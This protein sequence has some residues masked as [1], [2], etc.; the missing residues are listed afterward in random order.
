MFTKIKK[1]FYL[2]SLI[3]VFCSYL[4]QSQDTLYVEKAEVSTQSKA[5]ISG[6]YEE[7]FSIIKL[8][9]QFLNAYLGSK[10][11]GG[12]LTILSQDSQ[13][14]PI[15]FNFKVYD[16]RTDGYALYIPKLEEGGY[17]IIPKKDLP[18][19]TYKGK[20][21]E[22]TY[23]NVFIFSSDNITEI[24]WFK[25]GKYTEIKRPNISEIIEDK[26]I[27][28]LGTPRGGN[29][30]P[31]PPIGEGCSQKIVKENPILSNGQRVCPNNALNSTG[32]AENKFAQNEIRFVETGVQLYC[33]DCDPSKGQSEFDNA[34][35]KADGKANSLIKAVESIYQPQSGLNIVQSGNWVNYPNEPVSHQNMPQCKKGDFLYIIE[36][37]NGHGSLGMCSIPTAVTYGE[38]SDQVMAH[39]LGHTLGV[40]HDCC[41]GGVIG[42]QTCDKFVD[43]SNVFSQRSLEQLNKNIPNYSCLLNN[44]KSL[45]TSFDWINGPNI[46]CNNGSKGTYSI[47]LPQG[48]RAVTT[49]SHTSYNLKYVISVSGGLGITERVTNTLG[50][51]TGKYEIKAGSQS[52]EQTITLKIIDVCNNTTFDYVKK[53]WVGQPTEIPVIML[54]SSWVGKGPNGTSKGSHWKFSFYLK[55]MPK[56]ATKLKYTVNGVSGIATDPYF[57][58]TWSPLKT[59]PCYEVTV[60]AYNDENKVC[61]SAIPKLATGSIATK[62]FNCNSNYQ[63]NTQNLKNLF[64]IYPNPAHDLITAE[65]DSKENTNVSDVNIQI[66][67]LQGH[68]LYNQNIKRNLGRNSVNTSEYNNGLYFFKFQYGDF[69][70]IKK[71]NIQHQ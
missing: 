59:P 20:D 14:K 64:S 39:E 26:D 1:C 28:V 71:I 69:E 34:M 12:Q 70:T 19:N 27:F 63:V 24:S 11:E 2:T 17:K 42:T 40:Q 49:G 13:E 21:F 7:G 8:D 47:T 29:P 3:I 67:D 53:I 62:K 55:N 46:L 15:T 60:E 9:Y 23:D 10:S 35:I 33:P 52:G 48:Y 37:Q 65:W 66:M 36:G 50:N 38:F 68:I 16:N 51:E 4:A 43:I 58:S 61:W 18:L 5:L 32:F 54:N 6:K 22:S 25:N 57:Y 56:G 44:P 30:P 45:S 31:N 41:C